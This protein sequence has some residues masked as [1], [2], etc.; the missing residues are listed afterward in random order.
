MQS[1]INLLKYF[2]YEDEHY[3]SLHKACR[4][5]GIAVEAV[6]GNY[7]KYLIA[8]DKYKHYPDTSMLQRYLPV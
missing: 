5:L 3:E 1:I 8:A 4:Q 7:R 6:P 2:D